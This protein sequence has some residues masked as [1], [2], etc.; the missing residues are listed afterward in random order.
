[1]VTTL[2]WSSGNTP[3]QNIPHATG[4]LKTEELP[5]Q[6]DN[7]PNTSYRWSSFTFRCKLSLCHPGQGPTIHHFPNWLQKSG[8][9]IVRASQYWSRPKESSN[10]GYNHRE[11]VKRDFVHLSLALSLLSA[12]S[13]TQICHL[14]PQPRLTISPLFSHSQGCLYKS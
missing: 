13:K 3:N 6:N 2:S 1:M 11:S 7:H 5:L 8:E 4:D 9:V 12:R 10:Q 14:S